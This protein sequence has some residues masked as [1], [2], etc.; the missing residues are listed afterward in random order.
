MHSAHD[1]L[2]RWPALDVAANAINCH[3]T[4]RLSPGPLPM[5]SS[6]SCRGGTCGGRL[7]ASRPIPWS[8]D[9]RGPADHRESPWVADL[10]GLDGRRPASTATL[11]ASVKG[12]GGFTDVAAGMGR[13]SL[14]PRCCARSSASRRAGRDS[15]CS[16]RPIRA[17][18]ARHRPPLSTVYILASKSGTTIEPNVLAHT[19]AARSKRHTFLAGPIISSRSP[20]QTLN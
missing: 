15:T 9:S 7:V 20:T 18:C 11:A 13:S 17:A 4:F 19:S 3:D 2:T 14:A 16:T 12:D 8:A 5:P 1:L 10:S 6:R